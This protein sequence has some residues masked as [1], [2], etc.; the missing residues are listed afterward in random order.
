MDVFFTLFRNDIYRYDIVNA[1][2]EKYNFTKYLEIGVNNGDMFTKINCSHKV[3]VDPEQYGYTTHQM[4]SDDFFND[5][6]EN[7]KFDI[8]FVDGLHVAD[9]CYRDIENSIK[10]LSDGGFIIC[11][12]M[13]PPS[14][15]YARSLKEYE[16]DHN[17]WNGDVYKAF[18]KFRQNY[19]NYSSCVLYDCDWGLGVITKG[20]GQN[21]MKVDIDNMSFK[22]WEQNK[23]VLMNCMDT[24]TFIQNFC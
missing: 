22:E 14:E 3:S 24:N 10:H 7:E 21:I 16:A 19:Q 5:L 11:H 9:Q 6:D 15:W 23:N 17:W 18:V 20:I 2:I 1:L 4:T 8:I 13:N 12:D